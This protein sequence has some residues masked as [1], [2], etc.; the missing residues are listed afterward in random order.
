MARLRLSWEFTLLPTRA[1]R[2][3]VL[4]FH[5]TALILRAEKRCLSEHARRRGGARPQRGAVV[6]H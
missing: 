1:L 5:A 6:A 4:K 2:F 3:E